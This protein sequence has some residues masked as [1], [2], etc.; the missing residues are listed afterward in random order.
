M[1]F[2]MPLSLLIDKARKRDQTRFECFILVLSY[3]QRLPSHIIL[4]PGNTD[5]CDIW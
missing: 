5:D 3:M 4:F 2:F 1:A